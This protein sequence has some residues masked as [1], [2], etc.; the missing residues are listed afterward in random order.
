MPTF[1]SQS[2]N[3]VP[4]LFTHPDLLRHILSYGNS[5]VVSIDEIRS[6][7]YGNASS[8]LTARTKI[9]KSVSF[10]HCSIFGHSGL[11]KQTLLFTFCYLFLTNYCIRREKP[12]PMDNYNDCHSQKLRVHAPYFLVM[13]VS[14]IFLIKIGH[15]HIFNRNVQQLLSEHPIGEF[16]V[17]ISSTTEDEMLDRMEE[18]AGPPSSLISVPT[19]DELSWEDKHLINKIIVLK[20]AIMQKPRGGAIC[21]DAKI[22]LKSVSEDFDLWHQTKT[23]QI[24][25]EY[26][27]DKVFLLLSNYEMALISK[28][29][30]IDHI[31]IEKEQQARRL[32]MCQ[33]FF[34]EI[35]EL[36][37]W[38]IL[39][40]LREWTSDINTNPYCQ[41]S[42]KSSQELSDKL[43]HVLLSLDYHAYKTFIAITTMN[44]GVINADLPL[45]YS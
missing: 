21:N 42:A 24:I 37:S 43:S 16:Q 10:T 18:G 31:E 14:F 38:R 4:P 44:H 30:K 27:W 25:P 1:S 6:D 23:T 33:A 29:L 19:E 11:A 36:A 28:T 3:E 20:D 12:N 13:L 32:K 17:G 2:K 5:V 35:K 39:E 34:D 45:V 40:T 7:I 26:L 8:T 22:L 41:L 15:T 9:A